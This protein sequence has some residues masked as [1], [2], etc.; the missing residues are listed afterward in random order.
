MKRLRI[1]NEI[2]SL[3][4]S[5]HPHLKKKLKASL[6]AILDDPLCGKAL[7]E[8]LAGLRSLRVSRFRII[9]RMG[10]VKEIQIV[11]IGPR[12]TIYEETVRIIRKKG[13]AGA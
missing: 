2:V 10:G 4:R 8:E 5:L 1:P 9:Y 6:Q 7:H 11:A 12:R 3:V 13:A